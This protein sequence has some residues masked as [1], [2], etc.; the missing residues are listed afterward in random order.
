MAA[1][2]GRWPLSPTRVCAR[3]NTFFQFDSVRAPWLGRCRRPADVAERAAAPARSCRSAAPRPRRACPCGWERGRSAAGPPACARPQHRR[4]RPGRTAAAQPPTG[5][6]AAWS[7]ATEGAAQLSWPSEWEA[8][9]CQRPLRRGASRAHRQ[10][11]NQCSLPSWRG[12]G[13]PAPV[14]R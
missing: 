3:L 12:G 5:P 2:Q 1:S 13:Q 10:T 8:R 11:P 6:W 9:A 4:L 14:A 7:A